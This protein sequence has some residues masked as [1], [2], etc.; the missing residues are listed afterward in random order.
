M[1]GYQCGYSLLYGYLKTDIRKTWI[2]MMISV[3]FWISMYGYAM[4]SPVKEES[5]LFIGKKTS[6]LSCGIGCAR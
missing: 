4:N 6:K 1:L 5:K 3:D 2:T